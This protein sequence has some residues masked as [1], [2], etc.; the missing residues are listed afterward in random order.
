[1]NKKKADLADMSFE[2]FEKKHG[3]KPISEK[4]MKEFLKR[5]GRRRIKI[6]T[7]EKVIKNR[8]N[9]DKFF[10]KLEK[11]EKKARQKRRGKR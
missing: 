11:E 4:Q 2:E 1:M 10:R 5:K 9:V 3:I 8:R 7:A 6:L